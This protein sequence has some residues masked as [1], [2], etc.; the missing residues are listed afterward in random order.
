[1]NIDSYLESLPANTREKFYADEN[2]Y[3]QLAEYAEL[4]FQGRSKV[5]SY[6]KLGNDILTLGASSLARDAYYLGVGIENNAIL[7]NNIGWTLDVEGKHLDAVAAYKKSLAFDE[8]YDKAR[9]NLA[10]SLIK[11]AIQLCDQRTEAGAK[12]ALACLFESLAHK[13]E[14]DW[15]FLI[16]GNAYQALNDRKKA[17]LFYEL[18]LSVNPGYAEAHNNLAHVYLALGELDKGWSHYEWR[19]KTSGFPSKNVWINEKPYWNTLDDLNGKTIFLH[20]EQG[21]GDMVQ[22][23]RYCFFLR[24]RYPNARIILEVPEPLVPLL[25]E[26]RGDESGKTVYGVCHAVDRVVNNKRPAGYLDGCDCVFPLM[27]LAG[28]FTKTIGDIPQFEQYLGHNTA[29]P[30][31]K[32]SAVLDL[33][34]SERN[35]G[36]DLV[37]GLNWA[38]RPTHGN[39]RNRSVRLDLLLPLLEAPRLAH[40]CFVSFQFGDAREQ[41]ASN[42][43][44]QRIIDAS[45]AIDNFSDAANII[46]AIDVFVTVDS[47]FLHLA[48]AMNKKTFALIAEKSDFRWFDDRDDTPWYGSVRLF[49]QKSN[50]NWSDT[51]KDISRALQ[52]IYTK[53]D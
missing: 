11:Q 25:D 5:V 41:I 44:S 20:W 45:Q 6:I 30:S 52:D 18:A 39:D 19:F 23:S 53:T 3:K 35:S 10:A 1:M 50:G 34:A 21:F 31:E 22:F 48:G 37:V 33:I 16:A 24:S 13:P 28:V 14:H 40:A 42:G 12:G 47:A 26:L 29:V 17:A 36:K 38:G 4:V 8:K 9:N 7:F 49:R 46:K 43:L 27:S 51:V 2:L 32:V 15:A